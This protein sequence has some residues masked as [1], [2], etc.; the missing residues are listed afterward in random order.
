MAET[1]DQRMIREVG[2]KQ[3]RMIRA[4]GRRDGLWRSIAIFGSV[5]WSVAIPT[6]LGVAAGVWIDSRW[7]SRFSWTVML[8]VVGLI[9]G[10]INAW[11]HISG[12]EK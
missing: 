10:C 8:L 2:E 5:G 3:A 1:P 7:P 9:L 6:V 12:G 4:R 11:K